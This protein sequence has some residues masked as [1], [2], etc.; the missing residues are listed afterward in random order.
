MND[1]YKSC[2]KS[3]SSLRPTNKRLNGRKKDLINVF[4]KKSTILSHDKSKVILINR[5]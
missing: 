4:S 3:E 5:F 1:V 2:Q